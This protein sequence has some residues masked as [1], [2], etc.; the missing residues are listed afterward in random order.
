MSSPPL[1]FGDIITLQCATE[2]GSTGWLAAE[3]VLS[4]EC[5]LE[6]SV[7]HFQNCLWEVHIQR[8]YSARREYDEA[9]ATDGLLQYEEDN[10]IRSRRDFNDIESD[11]SSEEDGESDDGDASK[12]PIRSR[13]QNLVWQIKERQRQRTL[14]LESSRLAKANE[15]RLNDKVM[16]MRIGKSVTYGMIVQLRHVRSRKFLTISSHQLAKVE[17]ENMKVTVSKSGTSGSYLLFNSK[18]NRSA[19]SEAQ[20]RGGV[21]LK[22]RSQE[23]YAEFLHCSEALYRSQGDQ[24]NLHEINSSLE[25]TGWV[26]SIYQEASLRLSR[27]LAIG[28]LITL[29]EAQD[30]SYLSISNGT[31]SSGSAG[32]KPS[33]GDL[34]AYSAPLKVLNRSTVVEAVAEGNEDEDDSSTGAETTLAALSPVSANVE[35]TQHVK[36]SVLFDPVPFDFEMSVGT[37]FLW[38]VEASDQI[39]GG[40]VNRYS[41]LHLKNLTTGLYLFMD[42]TGGFHCTSDVRLASVVDFVHFKDPNMPINEGDAFLVLTLSGFWLKKEVVEDPETGEI[43]RTCRGVRDKS[44]ASHF[45]ADAKLHK[46]L[47]TDLFVGVQS[48]SLINDFLAGVNSGRVQSETMQAISARLKLLFHTLESLQNFLKLGGADDDNRDYNID[49]TD[50][51]VH[52]RQNMM[53]EQGVMESLFRLVEMCAAQMLVHVEAKYAE[54]GLDIAAAQKGNS[55]ESMRKH[56]ILAN[57]RGS[58]MRGGVMTKKNSSASFSMAQVLGEDGEEFE[59]DDSDDDFERAPPGSNALNRVLSFMGKN[60]GGRHHRGGDSSS[61][62]LSTPRGG[63]V[64]ENVSSRVRDNRRSRRSP[65]MGSISEMETDTERTGLMSYRSKVPDSARRRSSFESFSYSTGGRSSTI[66]SW[67]KRARGG[68]SS[69]ILPVT[70]AAWSGGSGGSISSRGNTVGIIE[71]EA[72]STM[73]L[74]AMIAVETF[75]TLCSCVRNNSRNQRVAADHLPAVLNFVSEL[76]AAVD[77]FQVSIGSALSFFWGMGCPFLSLYKIQYQT[78]NSVTLTTNRKLYATMSSCFKPKSQRKR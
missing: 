5:F 54:A 46:Q 25:D 48:A 62:S 63:W 42:D 12:D 18:L 16:A 19:A 30:S 64:R 60:L 39:S 75:V 70:H 49:S 41:S 3:G 76:Q 32:D 15:S 7:D 22:L 43:Q 61:S 68:S 33:S 28:Q 47:G 1:N 59:E 17:K 10:L 67:S 21:T 20:V 4:D 44:A 8:Q 78:T 13:R 40:A 77:C 74:T 55:D 36:P 6:Q 26:V 24:R 50:S 37:N 66:D 11:I 31:S 9:L 51:L 35:V 57:R 2:G 71:E 72:G 23:N 38:L 58:G 34:S 53:R 29:H 14:F 69:K 65:M 56:S 73:S 45:V 27:C 52:S